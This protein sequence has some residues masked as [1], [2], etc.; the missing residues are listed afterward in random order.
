MKILSLVIGLV[1]V[2]TMGVAQAQ[3]QKGRNLDDRKTFSIS[4]TVG[5]VFGLDGEV[6]E[7]TRPIEEIG[8]PTSGAPPEDY[9]WKELGF[10]DSFATV[11]VSV[12]K[13]W[14]Y[15][16][17][18][19]SF[20]H[21][22]PKVSST[23]DRDYYIGVGEV[24][25]DGREYEYMVIPEGESYKGDIDIYAFDMRM[26]ITPVS[27]GSSGTVQF[28]PWIHL[29]LFGFV[30]DYEIDAGPAQGVTQY[31]NPPRDYVIGGKG[32]GVT[33]LLVPELGIGGEV[34]IPISDQ[35][36]LTL[37]AHAAF[38]KYKGSNSDFGV[39]SRN[40]KAV[41]VDYRTIGARALVEV[42]L[43]ERVN[44]IAGIEFQYWTGDAEVRA[45]DK[46]D[47][48]VLALREKFD[49]DVTFEMSSLVGIVG[50]QF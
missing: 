22:T 42:E 20:L 27:F 16:T 50:L 43:N 39:S 40:E 6:Q 5:S 44:L 47:E 11:G 13:I 7:T 24:K 28:T 25:F 3:M 37:Q 17:L 2:L 14:N 15:I 4:L 41:D 9:S 45:K 33:G 12:E 34:R 35:V 36:R 26:L 30:G 19:G 8:G 23:A 18:Q 10:D 1:L 38:L 31:E 29:G 49:K 48:E 21:G 32:T 46:D